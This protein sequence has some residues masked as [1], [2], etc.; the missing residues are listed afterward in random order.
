MSGIGAMDKENR[1]KREVNKQLTKYFGSGNLAEHRKIKILI[2]MNGE[3]PLAFSLQ[4]P[5]H[6]IPL[7]IHMIF[8]TPLFWKT[9]AAESQQHRFPNI[10][11]L[12]LDLHK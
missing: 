8:P 3:G 1:W 11:L 7:G 5:V 4:P 10:M 6:D 9:G 12:L 2:M